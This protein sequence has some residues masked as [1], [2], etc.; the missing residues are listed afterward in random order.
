MI[1]ISCLSEGEVGGSIAEIPRRR[2]GG[3]RAW[4]DWK[5]VAGDGVSRDL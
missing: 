2:P 1:H 4:R 5:E 3:K